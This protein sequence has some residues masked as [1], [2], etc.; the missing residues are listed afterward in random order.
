MI[1]V[2]VVDGGITTSSFIPLAPIL[3]DVDA[4]SISAP[5]DAPS[6]SAKL[7]VAL[8]VHTTGPSTIFCPTVLNVTVFVARVHFA[9]ALKAVDVTS[10]VRGV[11]VSVARF[12]FI[13]R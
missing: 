6:L 13:L 8:A 9:G 12:A 11:V 10:T 5:F 7:N 1:G 3:T 2:V 4:V